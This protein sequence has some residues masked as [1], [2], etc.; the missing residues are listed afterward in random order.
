MALSEAV[1]REYSIVIG[2]RFC[3]FVETFFDLYS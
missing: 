3:S 1:K 2:L